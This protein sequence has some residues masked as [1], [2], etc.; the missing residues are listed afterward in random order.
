MASGRGHDRSTTDGASWWKWLVGAVAGF[1]AGII[2]IL[3]YLVLVGGD[4]QEATAGMVPERPEVRLML[5]EALLTA[6]ARRA[7]T[8]A[9][10][11][12]DLTDVRVEARGKQL[13]VRGNASLLGGSA[14]GR[15]VLDPRVENN[16]LTLAVLEA[17]L[18]ILPLPGG[19]EDRL[20]SVINERIQAALQD[21]PATLTSVRVV[22]G[23]LSA[24]AQVDPAQFVSAPLPRSAEMAGINWGYRRP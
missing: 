8:Q 10:P 14:T 4:E 16:T 20:E 3:L 6:L 23:G 11:P 22:S 21:L 7:Y 13:V 19:I 9:D 1:L 15:I 18:G 17:E 5:S 24:T 2:V 12:I